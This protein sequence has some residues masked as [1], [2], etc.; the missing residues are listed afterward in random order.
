MLEAASG[1]D[2]R[3]FGE[4]FIQEYT[5]TTVSGENTIPVVL[6]GTT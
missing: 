1:T 3:I 6:D 4:K 2:Y 5:G